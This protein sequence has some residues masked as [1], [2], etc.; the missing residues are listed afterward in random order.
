MLKILG[1]KNKKNGG[2]TIIETMI[3]VSLFILIVVAGVG[4][5]LNANVVHNK[6]QNMRSIIDN[7]SFIMEEMSRNIRT[8]YNYRCVSTW[9]VADIGAPTLDDVQSCGENGRVLLFEEAHGD[10]NEDVNS[11]QWVYVILPPAGG[12]SANVYKSSNGGASFDQLNVDEIHIDSFSGFQVLGAEKPITNKQQPLVTIHLSG[13][14]VYKDIT[15][16]F[17]IQTTVA[18]RLI[19]VTPAP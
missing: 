16:P 13:E 6:S 14:I 9:S 18:Q 8:G 2:Y 4:A 3:A 10:G 1:Q 11:D 17:S 19:D 15:T 12:G 7:L 5:L